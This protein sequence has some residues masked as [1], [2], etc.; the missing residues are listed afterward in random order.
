MVVSVFAEE[1]GLAWPDEY[2]C[3]LEN[4]IFYS[5]F[6]A[7]ERFSGFVFLRFFCFFSSDFFFFLGRMS[8]GVNVT[9]P[10]SEVTVD[11]LDGNSIGIY[12]SEE[13]APISA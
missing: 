2:T 13:V 1:N 9:S 10:S 7:V 11:F 4:E 5:S 12:W 8:S 3:T 6:F